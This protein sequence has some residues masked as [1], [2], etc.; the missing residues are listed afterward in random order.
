M[1]TLLLVEDDNMLRDGLTELFS[2]DGYQVIS[3]GSLREARERCCLRCWH[4]ESSCGGSCTAWR[5][6]N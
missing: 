5:K 2:R 3:A 6:K 1:T 4:R